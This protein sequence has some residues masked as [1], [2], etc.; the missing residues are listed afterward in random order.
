MTLFSHYHY[1]K[2]L[3]KVKKRRN[4]Q[5]ERVL[6]IDDT[7]SKSIHNY[8]NAI[9]PQEFTGDPQDDELLYLMRYLD[10]LKNVDDVRKIEKRGWR[11]GIKLK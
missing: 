10:T 6:I 4:E 1:V 8:G 9:Y 2:R 11:D 5:M 7:P 3:S